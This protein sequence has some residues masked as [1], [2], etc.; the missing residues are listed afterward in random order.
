MPDSDVSEHRCAILGRCLQQIA[1]PP[2]RR[3]A[4]DTLQIN[5]GYRCN[6]SCHALPRQCRSRA[7]PRRCRATTIDLVLAFL[8]APRIVDA[9]H[10]R[11]RAGAQSAFPPAGPRRARDGRARDRPLQPDH[12]GGAGPGGS[13]RVPGHRAGR[14]RRLAA[15]LSRGQC[16]PPARQ[17]RVRALDPRPAAAQR[18]GLR[19]RTDRGLVLN[20]VYNPQGPSLPPPQ[21]ALEADYKREL[22]ERFGIVFNRLLHP[23]QHADPALR[24]DPDRPG[25]ARPLSRPAAA[26]PSRRQP[27]RT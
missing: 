27:R 20:L 2:L 9:R 7:A 11:R 26:R 22:G 3:R 21:E 6:Q 16:R 18:A 14:D 12:P 13:R 5:V 23:R 24:R 15:V 19:P 1:F 17:G 8:R 10:H 25:R 4:L